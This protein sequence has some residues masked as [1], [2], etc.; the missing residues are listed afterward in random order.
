MGRWGAW[1]KDLMSGMEC[2]IASYNTIQEAANGVER[3]RIKLEMLFESRKRARTNNEVLG[4]SEKF[5]CGLDHGSAT[6]LDE[7]EKNSS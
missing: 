5:K 4:D 7:A 3:K 6:S 1:I 2:L